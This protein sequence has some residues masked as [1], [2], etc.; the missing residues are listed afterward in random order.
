MI[1]SCQI[2]VH[3]C[4][5][6]LMSFM[7]DW[8]YSSRFARVTPGHAEHNAIV[9]KNKKGR[10]YLTQIEKTFQTDF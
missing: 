5:M 8:S 6:A 2:A 7:L 10:F 4:Q 9:E 3:L 1:I